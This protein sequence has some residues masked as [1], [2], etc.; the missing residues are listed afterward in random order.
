[1]QGHIEY[2]PYSGIISRALSKRRSLG[3]CDRDSQYKVP[4]YVVE[5]CEGLATAINRGS[6][7]VVTVQALILL[8]STCTGT[9]YHRKLAMRCQRLAS[10]HLA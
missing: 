6:Q 2:E 4:K 1:M 10:T 3:A 9:D 8:E 5:M 7:H